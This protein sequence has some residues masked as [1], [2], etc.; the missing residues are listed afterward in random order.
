MKP[1][2]E[3]KKDPRQREAEHAGRR[4]GFEQILRDKRA[5]EAAAEEDGD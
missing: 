2:D 4:K 1:S 3:A 5:A